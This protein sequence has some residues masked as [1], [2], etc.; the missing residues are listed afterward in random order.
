MLGVDTFIPIV[1]PPQSAI[2][3]VGRIA[4]RPVR[5]ADGGVDLVPM[6]NL[7]LAADH[8]VLDGLLGA[9]FLQELRD[10]LKSPYLLL[11]V[12]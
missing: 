4:E 3:G 11:N 1:N 2:L 10:L 6:V 8:R 12:Y 5:A 9:Q 7:T